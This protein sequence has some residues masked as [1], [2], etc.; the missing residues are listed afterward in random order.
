[1]WLLRNDLSICHY[2]LI[3]PIIC[4]FLEEVKTLNRTG[5]ANGIKGCPPPSFFLHTAP[6]GH[7]DSP[8][9]TS[10]LPTPSFPLS[11]SKTLQKPL[12]YPQISLQLPQA[13]PQFS[14]L[15]LTFRSPKHLRRPRP[16]L[17]RKGPLLRNPP[18]H[19]LQKS[20]PPKPRFPLLPSLLPQVRRGLPL[21]HGHRALCPGPDPRHVP[22]APHRGPALRPLPNLRFP[23]HRGPNPFPDIR[24]SIIRCP[25]LLVSDL[26]SQLRAAL[27]FLTQ[28]GFSGRSFITCQTTVL[29]VSSVEFTLLPKIEYLQSLGLTYEEVVN[30][31]MKRDVAEL[32]RFPQYFLFSL[33]GKIKPRHRLLVEHDF[34]LLLREMLKV[35][36]GE[37]NARLI[38]MRLGSA[39]G[40]W[41]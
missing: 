19:R 24:K 4:I 1:M 22:T 36:D 20:P 39:D 40:S 10:N 5:P 14:K 31:E 29:L 7:H 17:P 6:V 11:I 30:M 35:S 34:S 28:L 21:L 16:P 18:Q 41:V 2:L 37:F 38:E 27:K 33:E 32:K 23:P 13:N 15:P 12:T 26:D 9:P 25:R 3:Q 8:S